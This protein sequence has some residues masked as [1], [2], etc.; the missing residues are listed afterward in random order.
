LDQA[1]PRRREGKFSGWRRVVG[2][3]RAIVEEER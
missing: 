3:C 2:E 1:A